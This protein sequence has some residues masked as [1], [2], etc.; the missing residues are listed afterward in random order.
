MNLERELKV[1]K[2]ISLLAGKKIAEIYS[3]SFDVYYKDDKTPLTK[4]D[5]EANTI[6][7]T[8]L[9]KE[10]PLYD[11]ISEEDDERR[12]LSS[13]FC[14]I[15]DPLDGT[16]EFVKRNDEFTVNIALSYKGEVILG[17][18][19]APMLNELYFATK[20]NGAFIE[21][22]EIV[23]KIHVSKRTSN[24]KVLSSRSHHSKRFE[25]FKNLNDEKILQATKMGSSLKGCSIAKGEYDVYYNFGNKTNIWDT[26]AMEIVVKEA[27]G[28]FTDL[29]GK[30][31]CYDGK[32]LKNENGFMI[33]NSM[34]NELKRE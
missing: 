19:Y 30:A 24:L 28:V 23:K 8:Q 20:G 12:V 18:V 13:E 29:N 7:V 10:F 32:T 15:I 5:L 31:I 25:E 21:K 3:E 34:R 9:K 22:N 33:L 17:V 14:F 2:E 1:A 6:I 4:A 16:K 27:G 26:A 11:I